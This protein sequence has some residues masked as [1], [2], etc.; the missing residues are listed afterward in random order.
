MSDGAFQSTGFSS[1]TALLKKVSLPSPTPL[2]ITKL[3]KFS[4][5]SI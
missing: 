5:S 3:S 4:S 1:I 2:V